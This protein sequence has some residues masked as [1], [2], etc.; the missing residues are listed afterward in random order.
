SEWLWFG[1]GVKICERL[2]SLPQ[3]ADEVSDSL[4]VA[5]LELHDRLLT[6]HPTGDLQVG[7]FDR[8]FDAVEATAKVV[9]S[10]GDQLERAGSAADVAGWEAETCQRMLER[11]HDGCRLEISARGVH[12]QIEKGPRH[13]L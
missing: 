4:P 3:T 9:G 2:V 7:S 5:V 13:R 8:G 1:A 12:D 6:S 11:D 10:E